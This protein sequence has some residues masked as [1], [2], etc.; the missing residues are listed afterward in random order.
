MFCWSASAVA[1]ATCGR[2]RSHAGHVRTSEA[3]F[4]GRA[5]F[6]RCRISVNHTAP[7]PSCRV[8]RIS[9]TTRWTVT[10]VAFNVVSQRSIPKSAR[11]PNDSRTVTLLAISSFPRGSRSMAIRQIFTAAS[12]FPGRCSLG[13]S[14]HSVSAP[15]MNTATGSG[16]IHASRFRIAISCR[17]S[18]ASVVSHVA[19]TLRGYFISGSRCHFWTEV[20]WDRQRCRYSASVMRTEVMYAPACSS[21]RASPASSWASAAASCSSVGCGFRPRPDGCGFVFSKRNRAASSSGRTS[22]GSGSTYSP[23]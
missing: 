6:R 11:S 14:P 7:A 4:V 15:K 12:G 8:R 17:S 20:S 21:A 13:R 22:S 5:A 23:H 1:N 9:W 18:C 2:S 19:A 3:A 16:A 10:A